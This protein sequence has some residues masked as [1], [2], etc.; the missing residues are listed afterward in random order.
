MSLP[1]SVQAQADAAAKHFEIEPENPEADPGPAPGNDDQN[2]NGESPAL[3]EQSPEGAQPAKS[4]SDEPKADDKDALYWQHR[5]QVMQGKYNSETTALRKENDEL[6]QASADSERRISE[7]EQQPAST[8]SGGVSDD[9]LS[10][11]KAEFGEDLVTF[12]ERM[13]SQQKPAAQPETGNTR[14]LQ[15]RLDRL[16]SDKQEDAQARF[17]VGLEQAVPSF[18]EINA[19]PQFMQFLAQFDP[20]TGSQ[21]QQSLAD[22]QQALDAKGVADVFNSYLAQAGQAKR[23]AVPEERLEPRTGRATSSP[24]GKQSWTRDAIS[25]FYRDKTSG[26]YSADEADRLEADIFAA[27]SEG[28][29]Q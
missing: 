25:Q 22:A 23:Q 16:E 11:F 4:A 8:S 7:M 14:E 6:K 28:R 2:P 12:V 26:R 1:K 24:Q 15:E 5:F 18:R 10:Q 3:D 9:Q 29:I 27:Q 17:W 13:V 21:R 20:T 19:D